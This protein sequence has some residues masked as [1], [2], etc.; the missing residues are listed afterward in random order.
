MPQV[1]YGFKNEYS[2]FESTLNKWLELCVNKDIKVVPVLAIYK[3]GVVDS[4]AGTGKNEWI[5]DNDI[6]DEQIKLI[7]D[8]KL[9]GYTLF[10]YDFIN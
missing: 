8:N 10:R 4:G 9:E 7:K 5:D 6:I 3:I 1:Y 2:P